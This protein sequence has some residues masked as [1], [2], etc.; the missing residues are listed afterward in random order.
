MSILVVVNFEDLVFWIVQGFKK[1]AAEGYWTN[2]FP[3]GNWW[4]EWFSSFRVLGG[5]GTATSFWPFVPRYYYIVLGILTFYYLMAII[6]G[7]KYGQIADWIILPATLPVLIGLI[8]SDF[9]F[10]VVFNQASESRYLGFTYIPDYTT[11]HGIY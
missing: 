6:G 7:P 10:I 5:W 4:D 3:A 11:V 2:P 8:T 9:G 1:L